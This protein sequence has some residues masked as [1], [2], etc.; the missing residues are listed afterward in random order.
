MLSN[1]D[2]KLVLEFKQH[3]LLVTYFPVFHL[4]HYEIQRLTRVAALKK[5]SP[6]SVSAV[7]HGKQ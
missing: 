1:G 3:T 2:S 6:G 4:I 7:R 5:L